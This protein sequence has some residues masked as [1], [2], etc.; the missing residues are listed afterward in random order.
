MSP[1]GKQRG[2]LKALVMGCVPFLHL[3]LFYRL[4]NEAKLRWRV[5][6]LNAT[7]YTA[8]FLVPVLNI[9]PLYKFLLLVQSNLAKEGKPGYPRPLWLLAV[10]SFPP[11][12][13][14][15]YVA[16]KTQSLFNRNGVAS[17]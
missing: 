13:G 7:L 1:M 14:W 9:Y 4:C 8:M 12:L 16:W 10:L 5:A 11:I 3:L 17:L 15:F 6:G 2:A